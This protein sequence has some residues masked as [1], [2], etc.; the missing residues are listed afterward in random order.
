MRKLG[1]FLDLEAVAYEARGENEDY[2][3]KKHD[4]DELVLQIRGR[5][6]LGGYL[7]ITADQKQ[8]RRVRL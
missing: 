1:K 2:I 8:I 5:T 7:T 6:D 3:L 4:G